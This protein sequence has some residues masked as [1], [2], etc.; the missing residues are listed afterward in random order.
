MEKQFEK[1]SENVDDIKS[2]INTFNTTLDNIEKRLA[3]LEKMDSIEHRV[4]VNQID[5]SDIKDSLQ[6][7]EETQSKD[8][9]HIN[10]RL[11]SHLVK[12]AKVEE[13]LIISQSK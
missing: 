4:E 8:I 10:R 3:R 9:Q 1:I 2:L 5:L 12:I 13:E 6:R 7:I 11:D